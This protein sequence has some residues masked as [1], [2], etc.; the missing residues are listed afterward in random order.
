MLNFAQ[1]LLNPTLTNYAKQLRQ[2]P[3]VQAGGLHR[4]PGGGPH[5]ELPVQALFDLNAFSHRRHQ[6][7]AQRRAEADRLRR[8]RHDRQLRCAG[9]GG[10][11]DQAR[12][13]RHPPGAAD[14][15]R[16]SS[17]RSR[18][19]WT[20]PCCRTRRTCT[21]SSRPSPRPARSSSATPA[22]TR[23]PRLTGSSSRW[24]A[25]WAACPTG[26]CAT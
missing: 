14:P 18:P 11:V 7:A 2:G 15:P 22:S 23:P 13:G 1:G 19:C 3:H 25:R 20:R 9:A 24:P 10:P 17:P 16:S 4:A 5:V 26:R 12:V 21:A 6:P 8:V